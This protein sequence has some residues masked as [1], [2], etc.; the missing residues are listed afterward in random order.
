VSGTGV[1]GAYGPVATLAPNQV[2][3]TNTGLAA[4]TYRYRI[5]AC[6]AAGCSAWASTANVVIP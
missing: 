2:Q 5:R 1:V 3:F 4:G 6:G